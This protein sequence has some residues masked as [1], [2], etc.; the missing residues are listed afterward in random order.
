[1][2]PAEEDETDGLGDEEEEGESS[3]GVGEPDGEAVT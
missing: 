2:P 3:E 1:L